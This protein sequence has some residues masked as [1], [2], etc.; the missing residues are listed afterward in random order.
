MK[1]SELSYRDYIAIEIIPHLAGRNLPA[2]AAKEAY[3]IAD[4]MLAEAGKRDHTI[5]ELVARAE[6]AERTLEVLRATKSKT[7]MIE[8]ISEF[9]DRVEA[10]EIRSRRTY[11]KFC[12]LLERK[13]RT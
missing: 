7:E 6:K 8:A 10:G 9:C 3:T 11:A 1:F 5:A 2:S 13:P 12:W 4:A